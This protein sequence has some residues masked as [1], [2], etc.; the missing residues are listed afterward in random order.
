MTESGSVAEITAG[1]EVAGYRVERLLGRGGMSVVYLAEDM[2]LGRRVAL[3]LLAPEL[4]QDRRFR[5]RF[6]LESRLAA[7]IDH[8]NVIPVYEAGDAEGLLY[9]AMRYVDGTDLRRLLE[10]EGALEPRRAVELTT[11][12]ADGLEAAHG[13]GLVHRDVKP[14]NVLIARQGE[15]EHVY[16]A[17]FGL[18]KTAADADDGVAA[19]RLS[20]TIDYVAPEQ[21][22]DGAASASADV[23]ALGCVLYQALTGRVPFPKA[24]EFETL[25]AHVSEP[26]PAPSETRPELPRAFDTVVARALAKQPADRYGGAADLA[27]AARAAL[28]VTARYSRRTV[29]ALALTLVAVIA[30]AAV[31]AVLLA[32]GGEPGPGAAP[33]IDLSGGALQR[34]DVDGTR[35]SATFELEGEPVDVAA[36]ASGVLVADGEDGKS[37]R[38]DPESGIV[39]VG[40]GT[41]GGLA[42][43]ALAPAGVW[44]AGHGLNGEGVLRRLQQGADAVSVAATIDLR[45]L[46]L[47]SDDP[48]PPVNAIVAVE[49][50]PAAGARFAGWVID[51]ADGSLLEIRPETDGYGIA[52]VDT[53]G[54][55]L[56]LDAA[57]NR[58]WVG[59]ENELLELSSEPDAPTRLVSRIPLS[60]LPI[61]IA[62]NATGAWVATREST[63]ARVE[64]GRIVMTLSAPGRPIDLAMG[65]GALWLL[66]G[67]GKL[68]RLDPSGGSRDDVEDIGANPVALTVGEGAVWVVVRGGDPVRLSELP[69]SYG[70]SLGRGIVVP[71]ACEGPLAEVS[72]CFISFRAPARSEDGTLAVYEGAWFEESNPSSGPVECEDGVVEAPYASTATDNPGTGRLRIERWGTLALRYEQTSIARNAPTAGVAPICGT[73]TG[74]WTGIAGPLRGEQGRFTWFG[75]VEERIVVEPA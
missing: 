1:H 46:A 39:T 19:A 43:V 35:L 36:T 59:Q 33:R 61:A 56:A 53:G 14:S 24:S 54:T 32:G 62:A 40:P 13:H 28:P 6:R 47:R 51:A 49:T 55:P 10:E 3:K 5:E 65:E 70:T 74:A 50:A 7:S 8:A 27:A 69:T 71:G 58:L 20:G 26:P 57:G 25:W 34:V 23:Y 30:G 9:I 44:L 18:T 4:S 42:G 12:V 31:A 72:G 75:P 21:I 45:E 38:V 2:A 29:L 48:P 64:S 52:R 66:T 41:A 37:Y 16:L 68:H 63:L 60:G 22:T 17:D 11:Q 15:H 73:L 67:D